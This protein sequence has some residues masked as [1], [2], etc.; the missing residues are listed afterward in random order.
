MKPFALFAQPTDAKLELAQRT[1]K[2]RKS[3]GYIQQELSQCTNISLGSLKRFEQKGEISLHHLLF[4]FD[5]VLASPMVENPLINSVAVLMRSSSC[6][7][8]VLPHSPRT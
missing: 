3:N 1:K 4:Q 5:I 8:S 2:I 6:S 7:N